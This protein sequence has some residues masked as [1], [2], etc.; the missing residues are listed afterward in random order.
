VRP[1]C[2]A[3]FSEV[4]F[5]DVGLCGRFQ[6]Q[7]FP[8]KSHVN[9]LC[10]YRFKDTLH[11]WVVDHTSLNIPQTTTVLSSIRFN[12]EKTFTAYRGGTTG[13][14]F[15]AYLKKILLPT[16]HSVNIVVMDNMRSYHVKAVG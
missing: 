11:S 5:A 15:V 12:D 3:P 14:R 1:F 4:F 6:G 9:I 10:C 16:L 8:F 2:S 7:F 13:E